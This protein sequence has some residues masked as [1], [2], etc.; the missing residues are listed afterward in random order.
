MDNISLITL[1]LILVLLV[2]FRMEISV[3]DAL[4][5]VLIALL[6]DALIALKATQI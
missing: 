5:D 4:Q 6:I 1:A 3:R 2:L